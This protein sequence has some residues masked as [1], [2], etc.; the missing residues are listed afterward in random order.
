[1]YMR[2]RYV[3]SQLGQMANVYKIVYIL[4]IYFHTKHNATKEKPKKVTIT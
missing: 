1:M 3:W 4:L 2:A